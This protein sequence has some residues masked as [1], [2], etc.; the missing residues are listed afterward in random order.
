MGHCIALVCWLP[1][2]SSPEDALAGWEIG[3]QQLTKADT[4]TVGDGGESSTQ[5]QGERRR[6]WNHAGWRRAEWKAYKRLPCPHPSLV[7]GK[8]EMKWALLVMLSQ[9]AAGTG[10]VGSVVETRICHRICQA[11]WPSGQQSAGAQMCWSLS[12]A[13]CCQSL[14]PALCCQWSRQDFAGFGWLDI[15]GPLSH[16]EM[17]GQYWFSWE[18]KQCP[19]S[20]DAPHFVIPTPTPNPLKG[21]FERE[22]IGCPRFTWTV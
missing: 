13:L 4:T 15:S 9:Q 1:P 2:T 17:F 12:P 14:S 10:T 11:G 8:H 19:P 7:E 18:R 5:E 3:K 16:S 22:V 21:E 6:K 20:H